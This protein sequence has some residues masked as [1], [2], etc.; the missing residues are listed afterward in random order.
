MAMAP[1]R[2]KQ[3]HNFSLPCLKWGN[4]KYLRCIKIPSNGDV[5]SPTLL[6]SSG[7]ELKS[8]QLRAK[9]IAAKNSIP[10][11]FCD[12][13]LESNTHMDCDLDEDSNI[14]AVREKLL[15]DLEVA[16]KKLKVTALEEGAKDESAEAT[17][18]WN[19]RTRRGAYN[20]PTKQVKVN[21]LGSSP[22]KKSSPKRPKFSL[23][24]SKKEVEEDFAAMAGIRPPRRPKK[25]SRA[26][27]KQLD[28]LF[29]GL[30]LTEVS[31]DS[32]KVDDV[33]ES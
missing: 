16:A 8:D 18:P 9:S 20:V 17:R 19:L 10:K 15:L 30:W 26:V 12:S 29:P 23:S 28:L 5:P 33:P 1:E 7:S 31:P 24:L 27:Q 21:D 3:L 13:R 25:R 6:P 32:Y 14:E 11:P 22:V 4:Q 2:S